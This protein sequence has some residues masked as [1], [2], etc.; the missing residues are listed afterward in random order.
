M[1]IQL[2][3]QNKKRL[4]KIIKQGEYASVEEVIEAGLDALEQQEAIASLPVAALKSLVAEGDASLATEGSLSL[5]ESRRQHLKHRQ[6][7]SRRHRKSA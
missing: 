1:T 4:E 6:K 2:T 5:G 3:S 7:Q